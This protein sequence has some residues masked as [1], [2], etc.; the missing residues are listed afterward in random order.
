MVFTGTI[1]ADEEPVK[2]EKLTTKNQ[3]I[4]MGSST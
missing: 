4:S 2:G 3:G 1:W